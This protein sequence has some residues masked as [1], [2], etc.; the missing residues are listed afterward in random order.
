MRDETGGYNVNLTCHLSDVF[1]AECVEMIPASENK[2]NM[3]TTLV[4]SLARAGLVE[5]DEINHVV[6]ALESR[7]T[8]GTTA[9]GNGLAFPHTRTRAVRSHVGAIGAA[10]GGVDFASLD[11]LPVRLVFLLV[12][13]QQGP[14]EHLRILEQLAR[15]LTARA[16]HRSL[17]VKRTPEAL[18]AFI[19]ITEDGFASS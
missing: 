19:G 6:Q 7:E 2:E 12:S 10:P 18:L 9:I 1:R 11:G 8:M 14:S 4:K 15:L 5:S 16:I 3:L 17:Q 13:P